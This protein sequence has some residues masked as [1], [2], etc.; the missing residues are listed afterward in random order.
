M[1]LF[2]WGTWI[3]DSKMAFRSNSRG[4][5]DFIALGFFC[6]PQILERY[7]RSSPRAKGQLSYPY[8]LWQDGQGD[9]EASAEQRARGVLLPRD[10][11]PQLQ[12]HNYIWSFILMILDFENKL[13]R[14]RETQ[15]HLVIDLIVHECWPKKPGFLLGENDKT[16][17]KL[18]FVILFINHRFCPK[19]SKFLIGIDKKSEK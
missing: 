6:W 16:G 11:Q 4:Y 12:G 9:L 2:W 14:I 10:L 13:V 1:V 3:L 19:I 17:T 15:L 8:L 5:K 7:S 18:Y